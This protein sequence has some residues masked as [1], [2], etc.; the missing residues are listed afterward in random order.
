[1]N[2]SRVVRGNRG[3]GKQPENTVY[4]GTS[5]K[6]ASVYQVR[7]KRNNAFKIVC[8]SASMIAQ[9][10]FRK[11][12]PQDFEYLNEGIAKMIAN[13]AYKLY[14]KFAYDDTIKEQLKG[15]N[16]SCECKKGEPCHVDILLNYVNSLQSEYE[17]H[18]I[19]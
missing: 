17:L 8:T 2:V 12:C 1:M 5:S 6:Y 7:K 15:K 10:I 18:R 16:L 13:E 11:S 4:C 19:F 14:V 9:H 3:D